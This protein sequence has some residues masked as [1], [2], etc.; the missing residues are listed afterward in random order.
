[1]E[2]IILQNYSRKEQGSNISLTSEV[3]ARELLDLSIVIGE[4]EEG[5]SVWSN[6]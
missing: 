2:N 4:R 3:G 1:M 6:G 5:I